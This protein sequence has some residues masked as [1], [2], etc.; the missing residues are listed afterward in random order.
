MPGVFTNVESRP[1]GRLSHVAA[2][3]TFIP[4]EFVKLSSV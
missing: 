3:V 4:C 2:D 1:D